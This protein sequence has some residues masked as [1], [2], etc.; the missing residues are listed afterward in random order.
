[1]RNLSVLKS[2]AS[3]LFIFALAGCGKQD[4]SSTDFQALKL[5]PQGKPFSGF[6]LTSHL[7]ESWQAEQFK[8]E[9]SVVFFGFANCPDICPTTLLDLQIVEQK[10]KATGTQPPRIIFVSVDPDRDTPAL[11]KDYIE[12][13]NPD[14]Y[15]LTGDEANIL[16]IASQLGVAYR[17]EDHEIGDQ[18]YDVDHASAL[19]VI[20]PQGE[21]IGLF[22]APHQADAI[23]ADLIQL[24][25]QS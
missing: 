6:Q 19:F 9:Y 24:I 3:M 5:F 4:T 14:F 2:I 16:S 8:G 7:S 10:I 22:T 15:A 1:M 25:N 18:V 23:A 20:N 13:F 21:R 12:Y 11:L 17:V